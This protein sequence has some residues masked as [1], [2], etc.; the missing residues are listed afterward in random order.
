MDVSATKSSATQ[1]TQK[2]TQTQQTRQQE[3][4]QTR[5][6]EEAPKPR[7]QTKPTPVVNTQGQTTGRLIN[8]TA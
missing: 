2:L 1:S 5:A 3:Q 6:R 4:I 7:E 8:V